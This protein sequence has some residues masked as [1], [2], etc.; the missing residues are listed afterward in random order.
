MPYGNSCSDS[1]PFQGQRQD[2]GQ[3]AHSGQGRQ[4]ENVD[5]VTRTTVHRQTKQ[6]N[7]KNTHKK[8]GMDEIPKTLKI[9]S[10]S[11]SR[12][13]AGNKHTQNKE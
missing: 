3:I 13:E 2:R 5:N 10:I 4:G 8:K 9:P 11:E 6:S 7:K 12:S 1:R